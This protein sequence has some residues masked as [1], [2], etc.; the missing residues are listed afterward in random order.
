VIFPAANGRALR[1]NLAAPGKKKHSRF[2]G[3]LQRGSW[4]ID[5]EYTN[6]QFTTL[7]C[8]G[9]LDKTNNW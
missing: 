5:I 2:N 8:N 1:S 7:P 9:S 3:L 4:G 6:C